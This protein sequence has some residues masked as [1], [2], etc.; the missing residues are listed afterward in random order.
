MKDEVM[1]DGSYC[2]SPEEEKG[3]FVWGWT[4]GLRKGA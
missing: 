4:G 2:L 1:N 3:V